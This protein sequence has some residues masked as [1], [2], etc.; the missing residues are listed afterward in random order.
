MPG[1]EELKGLSV[2]FLEANG[3]FDEYMA[4]CLGSLEEPD[5]QLVRN[6]I[7]AFGRGARPNTSMTP[8]LEL[9]LAEISSSAEGYRKDDLLDLR[10]IVMVQNDLSFQER[11][12]MGDLLASLASSGP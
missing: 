5:E 9:D 3:S 7:Y 8:W 11:N 6:F 10:A 1:P 12:Q 2:K 4:E